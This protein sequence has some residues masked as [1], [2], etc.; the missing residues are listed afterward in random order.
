MTEQIWFITG[1]TRGFGRALAVA[2]LEAGDRV[3]A[4]ARTPAQLRDLVD[5][6]GDRVLP[7]ELDVTDQAAAT[8]AVEATVAAFGRI[9]VVVNN[10]GYANLGPIET[11]PGDDF[12]RQFDTNFWGVYHVTLAALPILKAQ[13]SGTI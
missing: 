6:Y 2:A 13:G 9:D 4:T 1:S 5:K 3:A 12:R 8:A 10:A 11:T 7:V